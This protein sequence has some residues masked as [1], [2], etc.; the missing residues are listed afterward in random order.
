MDQELTQLIDSLIPR[1]GVK[2]DSIY[3]RLEDYLCRM[4][5]FNR[6]LLGTEYRM[7][8]WTAL[9]K[10]H[11]IHFDNAIKFF[12][13]LEIHETKKYKT[14][15]HSLRDIRL[16]NEFE[17][18][19]YSISTTL[20]SLV[21]VIACFI[22]NATNFHSHSKLSNLLAKHKGFEDIKSIVTDAYKLWANELTDRRDAAT[23]NIALS[24]NSSIV[25]S[26]TDTVRLNKSVVRVGITKE[27]LKYNS[28]WDDNLP[29]IGGANLLSKYG[30]NQEIH[31]LLDKE[32]RVI[33]RRE[34]PLPAKPE[35]IDGEEY[36]E[37]L[38]KNFIEY[39][40]MLLL[41]LKNRI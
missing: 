2:P 7:Q 23:H 18:L 35:L 37:S 38:Y 25:V 11:K 9:C 16:E 15:N 34:V 20:S 39:V 12:D 33:V 22:Q 32:E 8:Q 30:D 19:L 6:K 5:N 14:F 26:K 1:G 21:R 41:S 13:S 28:L 3:V 4:S 29:V 10:E 24:V 31:E 27:P 17:T 40:R 36:V